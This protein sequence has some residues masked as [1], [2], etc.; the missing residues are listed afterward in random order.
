MLAARPTRSRAGAAAALR[1]AHNRSRR[2]RGLRPAPEFCGAQDRS[3]NRRWGA[4]CIHEN[5]LLL[6]DG[7][8]NGRAEDAAGLADG[9][10]EG[11]RR[12]Q[13]HTRIGVAAVLAKRGR[14]RP[15]SAATECCFSSWRL[16]MMT[17]I[18][19]QALQPPNSRSAGLK[20]PQPGDNAL[21]S[22]HVTN[23]ATTTP[24]PSRRDPNI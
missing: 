7:L 14:S 13:R 3:S 23:G 4:P 15:G 1:A 17:H 19:H 21:H 8:D 18:P 5:A 10:Y 9:E 6:V 22:G 24:R 11:R 12:L 2:T 16:H 20:R